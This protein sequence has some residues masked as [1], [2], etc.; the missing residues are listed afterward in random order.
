MK[1]GGPR[2]SK[3]IFKTFKIAVGCD[4]IQDYKWNL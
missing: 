4:E 1:I 3:F 2:P